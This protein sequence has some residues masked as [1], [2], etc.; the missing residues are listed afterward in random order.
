MK[1]LF[2]L[3]SILLLSAMAFGQANRGNYCPA[4]P[5]PVAINL[6]N[7]GDNTVIAANSNKRIFVWKAFLINSSATVD[8]NI[9]LKAG[10]TAI[11]GAFL[12]KSAPANVPST[13]FI[14]PCDNSAWAVVPKGSGF[15][16]NLSAGSA[17]I[18][19]TVYYSLED[20]FSRA[21]PTS[22]RKL[23]RLDC[24]CPVH[25]LQDSGSFRDSTGRLGQLLRQFRPDQRGRKACWLEIHLRVR[26]PIARMYPPDL[27]S[28]DEIGIGQF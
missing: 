24:H 22:Q 6:T 18:Q 1:T 23:Y 28:Q 13:E 10:T 5:T 3:F 17:S 11:S 15:I 26:F 20:R 9:T 25:S 27:L 12:L 8:N 2:A 4:T 7:S 16:V 19:G 21:Y 14:L